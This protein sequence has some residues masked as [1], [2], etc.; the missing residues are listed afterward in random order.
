MNHFGVGFA[1]GVYP[2]PHRTKCAILHTGGDDMKKKVIIGIFSFLILIT[3]IGFI[4]GAMNTYNH[5]V[6]NDDILVGL[7]AV[8]ILGVGGFVILYEF[9]L[10]YTVYYFFVK[11][12]TLAKSILSGFSNLTL[13]SIFFTDFIAHFL[14]KNVSE[15]FGEESIV[16]VALFFI[17]VI[18]R[19]VCAIIPIKSSVKDD[20]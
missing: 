7:G 13:F 20:I 3:A 5:E 11:P 19:I 1:D 14:F 12:K 10:F 17:Y 6:A 2:L 4:I 15:I 18:L 9:D 16:L 8:M